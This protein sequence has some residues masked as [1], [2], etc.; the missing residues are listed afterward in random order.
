[1]VTIGWVEWTVNLYSALGVKTLSGGKRGR[2]LR[3]ER[4]K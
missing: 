4:S 1:V 3:R 2:D